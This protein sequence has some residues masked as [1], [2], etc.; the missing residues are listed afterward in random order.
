M[1]LILFDDEQRTRF[2]P[3]ALTRPISHFR[4]GIQTL[5]EK[6]ERFSSLKPSYLVPEYLKGLFP[7]H[8]DEDNILINSRL[9]PNEELWKQIMNLSLGMAILDQDRLLAAR[10]PRMETEK[11]IQ[12]YIHS[13]QP[14]QVN[15]LWLNFPEDIIRL[16]EEEMVNDFEALTRSGVSESISSTNHVLG[17][18][19][20][21]SGPISAEYAIINTETGPVY[22]EEGVQI[23]EG[24]MI[25]GPVAILSHSVVKMGSKIYGS[26]SIGPHCTVG[27][28]VKN[29]N[30]IGF[31]NKGHEGYLGDSIIGEWCNLG[32]DT[33]NS[34]MKNNYGF[35]RM[36]DYS[37]N[38]YR[39]TGQ[40]FLGLMMG[41]H[42]KCGINS[43]INTGTVFGM[44]V[45]WFGA[46][47]SPGF[48]PDFTW[49]ESGKFTEYRL[50]KMLETASKAMERRQKVLSE[51]DIKLITKIFEMTKTYRTY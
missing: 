20:W 13:F 30:I 34:N 31:S 32:A 39:L 14:L 18:R 40:K 50:E 2:Y 38:D 47:L 8:T 22:I 12:A 36:F 7:I 19:L 33:N 42:V 1:N 29:S 49:S 16:N 10:I 15:Y 17:N 45:N 44:G 37:M 5:S 23:M 28:E 43:T 21:V 4:L 24:A 48:I 26:T 25:R 6:W 3:I 35:V 51:G 46:A 27:G 9:I 11:P 41:D